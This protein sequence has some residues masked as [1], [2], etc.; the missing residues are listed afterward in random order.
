M[1]ADLVVANQGCGFVADGQA[2]LASQQIAVFDDSFG[3]TGKADAFD[4]H[5]LLPECFKICGCGIA[6]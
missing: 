6:K 1:V 2:R 3:L 4:R 5:Y